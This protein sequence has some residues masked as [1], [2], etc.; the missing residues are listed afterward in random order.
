MD[1]LFMALLRRVGRQLCELKAWIRNLRKRRQEMSD[2][3]KLTAS[4]GNVFADLGLA[5]P[6]LRVLGME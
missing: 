3:K 5:N 6:A 2:P 4:S 1:E